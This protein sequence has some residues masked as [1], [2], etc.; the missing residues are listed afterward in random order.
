MAIVDANY[1]FLMVDVG[2][3]GRVSDGGVL[4]NTL[5]WRK[6]SQNQ[7]DMPDPRE[8]SGSPNEKFPYVFIG[9]GSIPTSPSIHEALQQSCFDEREK[10]FQL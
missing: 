10:D 3:N 5:F 2:A 9:D 6:L 7:L 8:L 1:K 4:K